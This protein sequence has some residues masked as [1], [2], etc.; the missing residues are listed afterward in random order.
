MILTDLAYFFSLDTGQETYDLGDF[1]VL[2]RQNIEITP[3]KLKVGKWQATKL[4][5]SWIGE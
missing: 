1:A 2:V 5:S 3:I 4:P